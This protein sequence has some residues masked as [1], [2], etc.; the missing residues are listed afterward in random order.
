M[1]LVVVLEHFQASSLAFFATLL[2]D[3]GLPPFQLTSDDAG[4]SEKGKLFC[5]PSIK[6]MVAVL[7]RSRTFLRW[8]V[9]FGSVT[10]YRP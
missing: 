1:H 3:I 5:S 7:E 4:H 9:K 6:F 8:F 2:Y 10:T